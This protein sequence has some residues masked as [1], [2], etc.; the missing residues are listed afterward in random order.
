MPSP[1]FSPLFSVIPLFKPGAGSA[2][3][4]IHATSS[5]PSTPQ[6][7]DVPPPLAPRSLH[8]P[9]PSV[10]PSP[11][12][13]PLFSVIPLFKPGAGSAQAGIHA[14]SSLPSAL[15]LT[16]A[17][18]PL[19]PRS[20]HPPHPS[21]LPSPSFPPL[22]SVIPLFKPGA[23]SAQAGIHATSSFPLAPQISDGPP[24]HSRHVPFTHPTPSFP[25]LFSVIPLFKP[26]AGSAQAGI[27]A[28]SGFPSTPQISDGP[29]PL[30]PR[31]LHPPHP[32]VLPSPSFPT[33][34]SVIP[35][36]KPGAGS[37][38]AGIHAT[39]SFP[40]APQ[41]SDGPPPL[42]PRSL[43]PRHP[44][45]CPSFPS[46]PCS[47]QG[48]ALR[49]QESMRPQASRQRARSATAPTTRAT[50]PAP[51]PP[52]AVRRRSRGE[53]SP[54]LSLRDISPRRAGGDGIRTHSP[55]PPSGGR[56]VQ[57][58]PSRRPPRRHP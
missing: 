8:P 50:L 36:F 28:T 55:H 56:T 37:A 42:A 40:S 47:S 25:P 16:D 4:G 2:Q 57:S 35:L 27:H 11:S 9:H 53:G 34:F 31:S 44:R 46:F 45:S 58:F 33:L 17:P 49:R 32:S 3:A 13:S 15:Q 21:V 19:A 41:I 12:F 38:Q 39:S 51:T 7:S 1:S 30:T 10:L 26:G 18:P 14:T 22:F 23:G 29:P 5:F 48:Q 43:H 20:L 52:P 54:L 6:I 24:H